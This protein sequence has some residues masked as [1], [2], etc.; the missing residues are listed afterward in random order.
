V[1]GVSPKDGEWT[2]EG[3]FDLGVCLHHVDNIIG[4]V[5]DV[6]VLVRRKLSGS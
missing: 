3:T 5:P 6:T 2:G 4:S 1:H